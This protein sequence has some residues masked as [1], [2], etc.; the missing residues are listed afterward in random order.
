MTSQRAGSQTGAL[1]ARL[2]VNFTWS[3][4]RLYACGAESG[5]TRPG[6]AAPDRSTAGVRCATGVAR[7]GLAVVPAA[8]AGTGQGPAAAG[9]G[10]RR[11]PGPRVVRKWSARR[12][13][14][15]W[16]GRTP[17]GRPSP[18][19]WP[20][21]WPATPSS[22]S[23]RCSSTPAGPATPEWPRSPTA[24]RPWM[25]SPS[26]ASTSSAGTPAAA[27]A[28]APSALLHQ[29]RRAG[30]LLAG[31]AGAHRPPAGCQKS[32]CLLICRD[33]PPP[34][35]AVVHDDHLCLSACFT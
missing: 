10:C 19:R 5:L 21:T 35:L 20:G 17:A 3:T 24:A 25:P 12:C 14:C 16:T 33:A 30:Q 26:A 23:G 15:R 28:P 1:I 31:P 18:W 34:A 29:R 32:A 4:T 7:S 6:A 9:A 13:R 11:S 27:A 2:H 8:A 22:G